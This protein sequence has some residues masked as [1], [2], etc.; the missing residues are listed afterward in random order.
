VVET[1]P[2][3]QI[4]AAPA[5]PYTRRLVKAT[6][7]LGIGLRDL[8]PT[9]GHSSNQGQA[10]SPRVERGA[11]GEPLFVVENLVKEYPRNTMTGSLAQL[12]GRGEKEQPFRAV[13]S[14]SFTIG[15]GESVGSGKSTTSM[16]VMRLIDQTSGKIEFGGEDIGAIPAGQFAMQLTR[17]RIQMVFQD[18]TDSLNPAS[19]RC[20]P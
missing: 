13:D 1:A 7:C 8:L 9:E 12:F 11:P 10:L 17:K 2:S 6:P 18:P 14:I 16:M 15:R 19:P 5:H 20:A 3:R 4:F